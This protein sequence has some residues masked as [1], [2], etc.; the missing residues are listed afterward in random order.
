MNSNDNK[1]IKNTYNTVL[2]YNENNRGKVNWVSLVKN[3]LSELGF[4]EVW[5]NQGVGNVNAF[6]SLFK[7]RIRDNYKQDWNARINQSPIARFYCLFSNFGFKSYLNLDTAK[8]IRIYISK[9]RLSS[10]TLEIEKGRYRKPNPVPVNER[11]CNECNTLEDEFHF[12]LECKKYQNLRTMYIKRYYWVRPNV[13]KLI[14]LL[15]SENV[16]ECRKLGKFIKH[17]F[18]IKNSN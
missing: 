17:A 5:I 11:K 16:N 12:L 9:L 8:N 15:T 7:Q 14:T 2:Q 10:H 18:E 6:L 1:Y 4:Y 3:L 13:P